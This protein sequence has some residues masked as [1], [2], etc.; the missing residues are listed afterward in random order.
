METSFTFGLDCTLPGQRVSARPGNGYGH[1]N[2]FVDRLRRLHAETYQR[3]LAQ[4]QPLPDARELLIH[5]E[6]AK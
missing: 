1:W 2:Y 4:I 5:L 6:G 3:W